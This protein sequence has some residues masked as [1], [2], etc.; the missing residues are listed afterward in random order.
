MKKAVS[1]W[2]ILA[3]LV[4]V[5][6]LGVIIPTGLGEQKRESKYFAK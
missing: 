3:L 2:V 6:F 1:W 5:A 4:L